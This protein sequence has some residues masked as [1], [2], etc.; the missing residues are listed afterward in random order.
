[1]KKAQ[2]FLLV[3]SLVCILTVIMLST[4]AIGIYRD[5]SARRAEDPS[6][7]IYTRESA[8]FAAAP[9]AG[10]MLLGFA[11]SIAGWVF[12]IRDED[13][14]K[15]V[16]D[17]E[18]ARDL[19]CSRILLPSEDMKKERSLQNKLL[20]G[21]WLAF[22]ICMIPIFLYV[23]NPSHFAETDAAGLE[24]VIGGLV[25]HILP[26][27]VLA[28][29]FL[30]ISTRLIEKSMEREREAAAL[31]MK[32]EKEKGV[33]PE[34]VKKLPQVKGA[35]PEISHLKEIRMV[36]LAAALLFIVIGVFNGSMNDVL[37]KAVKVCTECIGLG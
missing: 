34:A 8:F 11:I 15:G 2:I 37:V 25:A 21:R 7:D 35:M 31:R 14:E 10:V 19:T 1:M 33:D 16:K 20:K 28:L 27:I 29:G 36:F 4:A 32:E 9:G 3:Q 18:Y 13:V 30:M 26:W 5:G 12:K 22:F 23:I 24:R 17:E 6:A